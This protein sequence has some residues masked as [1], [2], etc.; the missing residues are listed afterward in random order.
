[1]ALYYKYNSSPL[2]IQKNKYKHLIDTLQ[3]ASHLKS[4]VRLWLIF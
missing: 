4:G 3:G 1:M 2:K